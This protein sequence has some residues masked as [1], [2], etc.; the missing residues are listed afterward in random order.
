MST[1]A[2]EKTV[3]GTVIGPDGIPLPGVN[4]IIKGAT[5]R[6]TQTDF[7]GAYSLTAK[8]EETL[9]FSFVGFINQEKKIGTL[10]KI[11]VVLAEST[12]SLD[13]V[14]VVAYGTTTRGEVT[15]SVSTVSGDAIENRPLTNVISALEGTASGVQI[16]SGSGQPGSAPSIRIRGFGS[17]NS[18]QEPLYIVDGVV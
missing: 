1:Y 2:Q 14:I 8:P 11:D 10:S 6:G 18:S 4:V 13:E 16:A 5:N 7:D 12:E 3:S 15:G 17:V 9:V